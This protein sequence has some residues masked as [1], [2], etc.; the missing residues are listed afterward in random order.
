MTQSCSLFD[1]LLSFACL[2]TQLLSNTECELSFSAISCDLVKR[3][4][5]LDQ[6]NS[7]HSLFQMRSLGSWT[8]YKNNLYRA[9]ISF[10]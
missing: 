4:S 9:P 8:I 10:E 7:S 3:A 5:I 6:K 2:H 1:G